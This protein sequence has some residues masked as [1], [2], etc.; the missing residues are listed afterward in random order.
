[1]SK[2]TPPLTIRRLTTNDTQLLYAFFQSASER[3]RFLMCAHPY[4]YET[5]EKLT[6]PEQIALPNIIRYAAVTPDGDSEVMAGYL[7]FWDWDR[8]VPWLGIAV[9]DRFHGLGIGK[10]LMTFAEETARQSGKGGIL[11]TTKKVNAVAFSMYQKCGYE[12]IGESLQWGPDHPPEHLL[13]LNFI[14]HGPG[15]P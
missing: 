7:F 1:M 5:A 15:N 9:S 12:R 3:T 11:L 8:K 4:D 2:N 6:S 13:M 14:D 10:R